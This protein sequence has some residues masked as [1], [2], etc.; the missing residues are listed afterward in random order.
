MPAPSFIHVDVYY[1][2]LA[3]VT[4]IEEMPEGTIVIYTLN[5]REI[6][7]PAS[8]REQLEAALADVRA[9]QNPP[10]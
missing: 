1:I 4:H 8:A 6:F 9:P 10:D 3:N 7:L 2:N 5:D